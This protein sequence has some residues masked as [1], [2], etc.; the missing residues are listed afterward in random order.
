MTTTT[1]V[2]KSGKIVS[3]STNRGKNFGIGRETQRGFSYNFTKR[4]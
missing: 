3:V 2:I 1:Y 4:E